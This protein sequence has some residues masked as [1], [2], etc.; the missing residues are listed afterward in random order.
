MEKAV[1]VKSRISNK[2]TT[3]SNLLMNGKIPPQ[4]IDIEQAVLGAILLDKE[5]ISGV[6]EVLSLTASDVFYDPK[7]QII[8]TAANDLYKKSQPVDLITIV[9]KLKEN[10]ELELAGGV[11]YLSQLTHRIASTSN[12]EYYVRILVEKYMLRELAKI[13]SNINEKAFNDS[14]DV[15]ELLNTA[16]KE[17]FQLS[18]MNM[19]KKF[20]NMKDLLK[21]AVEE[22]ETA[23]KS[24]DHYTGIPTGFEK[25]DKITSGW[26]RS[27]LIVLAA[28]PGMGKTAFVLSMARNSAVD[29]NYPVAIFSLEM[30][31]VQLVKRLIS[32]ETRI[33]SERLRKGDISLSEME[34]LRIK[35]QKLSA[36]PIYI[37]DTPGLS[38]SELRTKAR[39]LKAKHGVELIIIDYLQLMSTGDKQNS[40]NR[41]QEI[42]II[43][44]T[45]KEVAKELNVPIIAL[46]QLS[47]SVETRGGD[48]KPLL[49][50]LRESGS[51][52]QDADIVSFIYRPD[53]YGLH[54]SSDNEDN[55]NIGEIII[56]KHRNGSLA[57]VRLRFVSEFALFENLDSHYLSDSEFIQ[58][59]NQLKANKDFD[60]SPMV[61]LSSKINEKEDENGTDFAKQNGSLEDNIPF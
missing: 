23:S 3:Q 44:R 12:L 2:N 24:T 59:D 51:I 10:K 25:L 56:A 15:F 6:N 60:Q 17:L 31:S 16:E 26:Q 45:I 61:V 36:A 4:A 46:S 35:A 28:R 57:T 11:V 7:H 20:E 29:F 52:E 18:E 27:D 47:R 55:H 22:I 42:S 49:S 8:Y 40:G 48:K 30:S 32:G 34:F 19:K 14:T 13:S 43:T 41:V 58:S 9:N 50:D 5:A 39:K 37:D 1:S 33:D 21:I 54:K 53:Y 38:V